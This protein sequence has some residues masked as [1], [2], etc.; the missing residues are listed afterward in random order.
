[1]KFH[2]F[3]LVFRPALVF[4]ISRISFN[5]ICSKGA[6]VLFQSIDTLILLLRHDFIVSRGGATTFHGR[7]VRSQ[8]DE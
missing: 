5:H 3:S 4:N 1:M 7:G 2:E 8:V 6:N